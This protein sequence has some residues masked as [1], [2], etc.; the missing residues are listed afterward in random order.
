[1]TSPSSQPTPG[2]PQAIANGLRVA[3]VGARRTNM[4][5]GGLLALQ[6]HAAGAEV[7][8]IVGGSYDSARAASEELLGSGLR[9]E[10]YAEEEDMLAEINPEAVI[11]AS[12]TTT[13]IDWIQQC[14]DSHAHVFCEKPLCV[15]GAKHCDDLILDFSANELL[16]SENCQW[17]FTLE[18][19]HQLHPQ[20][21]MLQARKFSMLLSPKLRGKKRW[22]EVL[23]HP[24]SLIQRIS[25]GPAYLKKVEYTERAQ[26]SPDSAL[27][28]EYCTHSRM[29][30]CEIILEDIGVSP[31]PA[32]YSIDDKL[33]HRI[34]GAN[35]QMQFAAHADEAQ[36]AVSIGDPME[37]S[38]HQFLKRVNLIKDSRA[39]V[40]IDEDL[41]RR[42]YLV[43][44]LLA[45]YQC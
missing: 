12:P 32:E 39:S 17:P 34:I 23:S 1:M 25:P 11:I 45:D 28:F 15:S 8:A 33:C 2:K 4:G 43:E 3:I 31:P 30:Q 24:L 44:A 37:Q 7:V 27:R 38:L 22:Q 40:A 5:T 26:D 42:Q 18:A 29:L 10:V 19:W 6:A 36:D 16:I 41:I 13:H 9:P 35:Y 21:D 20:H 14:L